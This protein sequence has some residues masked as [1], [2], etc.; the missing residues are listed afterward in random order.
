MRDGDSEINTG[1][2]RPPHIKRQV[3]TCITARLAQL[4]GLLT[5]VSCQQTGPNDLRLE[6]ARDFVASL[7][8]QIVGDPR[9]CINARNYRT[10]YL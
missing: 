4:T 9:R 8:H 1:E 5:F 2:K 3:L 7:A 10:G 6:P